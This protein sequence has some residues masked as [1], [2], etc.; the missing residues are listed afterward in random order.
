[1]RF[2]TFHLQPSTFNLQLSAFLSEVFPHGSLRQSCLL[3]NNLHIECLI[4]FRIYADQ[5]WKDT[6]AKEFR[7]D[8]RL[9]GFFEDISEF[10]LNDMLS[11]LEHILPIF[12]IR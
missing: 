6:L 11:T 2:A 4:H 12:R 1:M 7:D 3:S 10:E 9:F 5:K 8:A